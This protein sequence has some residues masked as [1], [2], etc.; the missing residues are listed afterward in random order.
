MDFRGLTQTHQEF[1]FFKSDTA[2][3]SQ[4]GGL[5]TEAVALILWNLRMAWRLC[6]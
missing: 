6:Q 1:F 2:D 4:G 3:N 5:L